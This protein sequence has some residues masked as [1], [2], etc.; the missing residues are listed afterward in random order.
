MMRALT[1]AL[2]VAFTA[3]PAAARVPLRPSLTQEQIANQYVAPFK[4]AGNVYYVG[5][6]GI[7]V[8]LIT[9]PRGHILVD[10]GYASSANIILRN[11]KTLQFAPTDIKYIVVTHAHFDHA[12][13]L[14]ELKRRT[15]AQVVALA[16]ERP[17]LEAGRHFGDTNYG[18]GTFP[19][20]K[21]DRVLR[22]GEALTVGG[23]SL[24]AHATPGHTI[25]CTSWTLPLIDAGKRRTAIFYCSTTV[26]GNLLVGNRAYPNI[27][28]DYRGSFAKLSAIHADIFLSNH[29]EFAD[30][31]AKRNRRRPGGPNPFVLHG[32]LQRF[33]AASK[34]DFE[35]ELA[36]QQA[37]AR[38]HPKARP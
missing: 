23:V 33:V 16:A 5:V 14:A 18:V 24:T 7:G 1:L 28:A 9:T 13:G 27:V 3:V 11:V 26:A 21:V 6:N 19:P 17:A 29:P 8:Y 37:A 35:A 32:E 4:V 22:D 36:R 15:G 10:G 12:G 38:T 30:I 2:A 25:G 31:F 20:V 34:R